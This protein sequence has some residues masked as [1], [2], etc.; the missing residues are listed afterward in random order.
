MSLA[1]NYVSFAICSTIF[2]C[3][4]AVLQQRTNQSMKQPVMWLKEET[5]DGRDACMIGLLKMVRNA[6]LG[7][8]IVAVVACD[9]IN[10]KSLQR[11]AHH[12]NQSPFFKQIAW[13]VSSSN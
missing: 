12:S 11:F 5:Y 9:N 2:T 3:R 7:H 6:H 13:G 4:L 10:I 8:G 1:G